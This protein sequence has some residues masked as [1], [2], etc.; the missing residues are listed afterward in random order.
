MV[1]SFGALLAGRGATQAA[2]GGLIG[3]AGGAWPLWCGG[4]FLATLRRC[5]RPGPGRLPRRRGA[6]GLPRRCP[7]AVLARGPRRR[8][9]RRGGPLPGDV[10]AV[11]A[12]PGVRR[13]R[14]SVVPEARAL[15]RGRGFRF[16][17]PLRL[18]HDLGDR[19]RRVRAAAPAD[20]AGAAEVA[21]RRRPASALGLG[22]LAGGRPTGGARAEGR[23]S[24]GL[25]GGV[26]ARRRT[27][28]LALGLEPRQVSARP[29]AGRRAGGLSAGA[30]GL[31]P[32]HARPGTERRANVGQ[33][34][35]RGRDAGAAGARRA[36]ARDGR[37][38][39]QGWDDSA[40]LA[41]LRLDAV[42]HRIRRDAEAPSRV[43]HGGRW[44]TA[45]GRSLC[46]LE[47]GSRRRAG[48]G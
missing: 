43:A 32:R 20:A 42:G 26:A 30:R 16:L 37:C 44:Q 7:R 4:G 46:A 17:S 9:R 15:L 14:R 27:D 28:D 38:G 40:A 33:R 25:Q 1:R 13:Q 35:G 18:V 3:G 41:F 2:A 21:R 47:F 29:W 5:S 39:R 23:H 36:E 12:G 24:A 45:G 34:R 48:L 19:R 31:P 22:L 6:H 10:A 11:A 8:G